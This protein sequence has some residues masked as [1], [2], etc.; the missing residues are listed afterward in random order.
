MRYVP[1]ADPTKQVPAVQRCMAAG[2]PHR[3]QTV[4]VSQPENSADSGTGKKSTF[5]SDHLRGMDLPALLAQGD[6]RTIAFMRRTEHS[7]ISRRG[8]I[9]EKRTLPRVA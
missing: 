7:S 2:V 4:C 8:Q 1:L 5:Q 3:V 9:K 6:Q